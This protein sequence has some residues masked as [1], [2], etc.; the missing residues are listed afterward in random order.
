[1]R[2]RTI[3][4]L[5]PALLMAGGPALA[6]EAAFDLVRLAGEDRSVDPAPGADTLLALLDEQD[7][8]RL[9]EIEARYL[10][11]GEPEKRLIEERF[12]L[13]AHHYR[14]DA[15]PR[16]IYRRYRAGGLEGGSLVGALEEIVEG[17]YSAYYFFDGVIRPNVFAPDRFVGRRES[18][19]H[20]K[21]HL[22]Q[23][24]LYRALGVP[25]LWRDPHDSC[26]RS[27]EPVAVYLT[28]FARLERDSP[29][30]TDVEINRKIERHLEL[31]STRCGY[32]R[33]APRCPDARGVQEYIVE[34]LALSREVA[35]RGLEEGIRRYI[36]GLS[37][38]DVAGLH[39]ERTSRR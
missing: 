19:V 26:V 22:L 12:G 4:A 18:A 36:E 20:E 34:P 23:P 14:V 13:F 24:S 15:D 7:P 32:G 39:P 25:C 38:V 5:L 30:Q 17:R 37:A 2:R 1:M 29:G 16:G 27:L 10:D 33:P 11:T 6:Q 21:I 8:D 28:E 31:E 35:R 9:H 3:S